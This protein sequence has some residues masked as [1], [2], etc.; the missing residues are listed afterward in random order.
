MDIDSPPLQP[1][2]ELSQT[3][4]ARNI[5]VEPSRP[6]WR[7]GNFE[8]L[9]TNEKTEDP[10]SK[11]FNANAAGSEDSEEFRA[12]F[13]DL[14]N[15][16]PLSQEAEGLHSFSD[17]KDSLPFDSKAASALPV[18]LPK[19]PPL[20]FPSPPQA[21]KLPPTVAISGMMP[22]MPSWNK[23]LEDFKTYLEQWDELNAQVVDHFSTRKSHIARQRAS[24]GYDFLGAR[25]DSDVQD[26]YSWVQ[27]DNFVRRKWLEACE[28]HEKQFR[29][30]LAF[31]E[32]MK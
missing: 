6:E 14:K 24:K 17:L 11:L 31:R 2:E 12:S 28:E 15:V 7:P 30:Y 3:H 9:A 16:A 10:G 29:A 8:G 23:Y 32:K 25:G 18:N 22:N 26:Y 4:D 13:G 1:A 27:Q 19:V 5:P 21:P 20:V